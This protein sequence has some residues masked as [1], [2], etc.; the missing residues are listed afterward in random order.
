ML[1]TVDAFRT[2]VEHDCDGLV[3]ELQSL[4]G[5][6][7]DEE[8]NAWSRSLQQL[9]GIFHAES[10]RPLHLYFGSRGNLALEYQLPSA[11]SWCDVVL[12]GRHTSKSA[13]VILELKHWQTGGDKP[14]R[15]EGLVLRKGVQE[16]HPSDQVRGYTEYCRRFHS[17]VQEYDANVHGCVLFTRDPWTDAYRAAPNDRL[18]ASYPLFTT[19]ERDIVGAFP[20]YFRE[21]LTE[22]DEKF[23]HAFATG[24]YRQERGFVAQIGAQ[25]LDPSN[26]AFE[27]LDGQRRAF[28]ECSAV[29]RDNF[30]AAGTTTPPK[31]VIIVKGPP[32]SG[33]SVIAAKL[34]ASLVTDKKLP[35]GDVVMVTTS[36]SQYSNWQRLFDVNGS[37]N[38]GA[39]GVVRK[40][41]HFT[42]ITVPMFS[43]LRK[44]YGADW[45][46]GA[47]EWRDHHTQLQI[48]GV[49]FK[50]GAEDN[51]NLV[52]IVDEAHALINPEHKAGIGKFGFLGNLGPQAAHIIRSSLLTVFLLDSEQG[53]RSQENTTLIDLRQWSRELG[54]GDPV[55]IDL[56]GL[57]FRCAGSREYVAWAESVLA[58]SSASANAQKAAPFRGISMDV[59]LFADPAS[60]EAALREQ[61]ANGRSARLLSSFSRK[62]QSAK[63]A[64]P[65]ELNHEAMDFFE[66]YSTNGKQMQWSRVWNY[67]PHNDYSWF[68]AGKPGGFI[69][70]D[71]LCEVGCTYVVRG[72]DFDYVGLLWLND[73]VWRNGSWIIDP[74]AVKETGYG[75]LTKQAA[76]EWKRG[77]LGRARLELNKRVAQA[78]RILLT[79]A[80]RG[81]F[82]WVPDDETRE[83]LRTSL[84]DAPQNCDRE[85]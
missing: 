45:L 30:H 76:A 82:I 34:W 48:R 1:T 17:A 85:H 78:Y 25:I 65:H 71:P 16:L 5:R 12:L 18:A 3:A 21:R 19:A 74:M 50:A 42:P 15:Y 33:K 43:K 62:W 61:I 64:R 72:F 53:F 81:V 39:R 29:I 55:E 10:F 23:A 44:K 35:T 83:Y 41:T 58:G 69:A 2:R 6:Y 11:S 20:A 47:K 38:S 7:G 13:A 68:V 67:I 22:P 75:T 59:R 63:A 60:M 49:P 40:A 56:S 77:L 36:L 37:P 70:E 27:L 73:L 9:S 46:E 57:Q 80:H 66:T 52:S 28:A 54:A 51:A 8:A 24:R 31:R 84:G 4:T 32:G 14:G 79:R 26:S